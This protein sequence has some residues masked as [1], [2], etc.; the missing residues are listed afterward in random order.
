MINH[1]RGSVGRTRIILRPVWQFNRPTP[2]F[3]DPGR[4]NSPGRWL[5]TGWP[6]AHFERNRDRLGEIDSSNLQGS[7]SGTTAHEPS[8]KRPLPWIRVQL[9]SSRANKRPGLDGHGLGGRSGDHGRPHGPGHNSS[10]SPGACKFCGAGRGSAVRLTS[11]RTAGRAV[12]TKV[13]TRAG[14]SRRHEA[15]SRAGDRYRRRAHEEFAGL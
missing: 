7:I 4:P 12:P 3:P 14:C 2:S 10:R 9:W 11:C 5:E 6:T 8:G 1:D 13:S 15:C